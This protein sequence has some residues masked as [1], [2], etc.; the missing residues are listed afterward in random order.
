MTAI[1]TLTRYK[2]RY[3]FFA[4]N[5]MALFRP[6]LSANKNF[7]FYKLLGCGKNGTFDMHPDWNQYAIFS[8]SNDDD[9]NI[10]IQQD[11]AGWKKSYYGKFIFSWWSLFATETWT[12]VLQPVTAHGKWNGKEVLKTS[13]AIV[14]INEPVAVLTRASIRP[15]KA[16]SF[17]KN[18]PPVEHA[19]RHTNGL[20]FSVGIGEMPLLRQATFSIWKNTDDMQSFA[21]QHT[22]HKN[23]I[24]KTRAE[25]WYSEELFAR[26]IPLHTAGTVKGVN[27]F[28][29]T[30]DS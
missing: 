26:F 18:V 11:Y 12:I 25:N 20:L 21:Y 14:S 27:P 4:L 16:I 30:V 8:I 28:E 17:W 19:M 3:I 7:H 29:L 1:L 23:V 5:A 9:P 2:N 10:L 6:F 15:S 24:Q 13:G 22:Q